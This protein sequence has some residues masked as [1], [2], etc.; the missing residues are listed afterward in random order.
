MSDLPPGWAETTLGEIAETSLGKMLD[1]G[2]SS[3]NHLVPYL[4]NVNVQW[5][6]FDLQEVL[7][8]EIP[9]N[10]QDFFRLEPG[11]LLVCE[12][13]DI[14]RCAIWPGGTGYMAFQ[15]ALHRIRPLG[16]VEPK[17]MRY[18]LE[19][20]STSGGLLP[21]ASGS[22][23]KHL[24]QEQLRRLPVRLPPVAE[25]RRI[26]TV[27]EDHLSRLD[28]AVMSL[29][30]SKPKVRLVISAIYT[31]AVEGRITVLSQAGQGM[32][33]PHVFARIRQL[34][35]Q[36]KYGGRKYKL[37]A[38]PD[39]ETSPVVPDG[40]HTVSLEAATD[41][42]RYIRYGILMPR[43]KDGGVVPYVEVKDL[44][45]GT[46]HGKELRKTTRELDEKFP[47]PGSNQV[48]WH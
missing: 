45:G 25:Q 22:T 23:I 27:L 26:V 7:K 16:G 21:F 2:K 6:R 40:W 30:K 34:L 20:L 38:D 39:L 46:L 5:G 4:R 37:P 11:D 41:P 14:G 44:A 10:Q 17:F 32:E 24:P 3:G 43:V 36:R 19:Y 9:P 1:R 28:A 31:A 8:M 48:T 18:L 13:G 47:Q 35:W 29:E 33:I 12:G 15:K 42:V